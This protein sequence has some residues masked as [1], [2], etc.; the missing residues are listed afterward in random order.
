M[1][2]QPLLLILDEPTAAIN[3]PTE[4]AL[5]ARFVEAARRGERRGAITLVVSHRFSTVR[6]A[7]FSVVIDGG[8][9]VE[10]GSHEQRLALPKMCR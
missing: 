8:H 6:M 9:A 1:R 3:A 10:V 2:K 7:D 4:Y 5:F